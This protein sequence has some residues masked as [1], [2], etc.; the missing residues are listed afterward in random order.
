MAQIIFQ[1]SVELIFDEASHMFSLISRR[2]S[3]IDVDAKTSLVVTPSDSIGAK[4]RTVNLGSVVRRKTSE[5]DV[6]SNDAA[7]NINVK[8]EEPT[9]SSSIENRHELSTND[10]SQSFTFNGEFWR[11]FT[12]KYYSGFERNPQ[13]QRVPLDR[14]YPS[15]LF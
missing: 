7:T 8:R 11:C 15:N 9:L 5:H 13:V 1:I 12:V 6:S 3:Q 2:H 4:I 10:V 14:F